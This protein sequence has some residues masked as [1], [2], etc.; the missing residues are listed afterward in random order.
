MD[1]FATAEEA[2]GAFEKEHLH[3]IVRNLY[4][5]A[6]DWLFAPAQEGKEARRG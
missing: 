1:R 2:R 6:F 5:A 4:T 3:G